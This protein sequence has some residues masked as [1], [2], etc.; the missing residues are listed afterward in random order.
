MVVVHWVEQTV[1]SKSLISIIGEWPLPLSANTVI[2]ECIEQS[3]SV[4]VIGDWL[5]VIDRRESGAVAASQ[6]ES[7]SRRESS[8]FFIG[9]S[10]S[11]SLSSRAGF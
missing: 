4:I 2:C 3:E 1:M 5:V 11:P 8:A 7:E 10:F 6:T 9:E